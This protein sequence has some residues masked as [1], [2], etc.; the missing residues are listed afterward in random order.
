MDSMSYCLFEHT[1]GELHHLIAR[2]DKAEVLES[3][4]QARQYWE[5]LTHDEQSALTEMLKELPHFLRYVVAVGRAGSV[6]FEESLALGLVEMVND[7][8]KSRR[9]EEQRLQREEQARLKRLKQ[10]MEL[11]PGM[12]VQVH[13]DPKKGYTIKTLTKRK[14]QKKAASRQTRP[15]PPRDSYRAPRKKRSR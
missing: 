2:L 13:F 4:E 5:K 7:A 12:R 1:L 8:V 11:T 6:E 3:E 9:E 14:A 15:R 10:L